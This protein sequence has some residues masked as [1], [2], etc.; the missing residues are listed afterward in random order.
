MPSLTMLS[1]YDPL[2]ESDVSDLYHKYSYSDFEIPVILYF[3]SLKCRGKG[4]KAVYKKP[5]KREAKVC[6]SSIAVQPSQRGGESF[7]SFGAVFKN[8]LIWPRHRHHCSWIRPV[9]YF[10]AAD[11]AACSPR[12]RRLRCA[13]PSWFKTRF[14]TASAGP[15]TQCML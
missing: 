11:A 8:S 4:W 10:E 2:R 15:T 12:S 5:G 3:R 6:S 7:I 14:V 13:V 1:L 9:R